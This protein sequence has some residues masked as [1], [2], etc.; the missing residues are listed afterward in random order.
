[1]PELKIHPDARVIFWTLHP[2]N[3]IQTIVPLPLFRHLQSRYCFMDRMA[4]RTFFRNLHAR[5][6][7]LVLAM[8]AE[9]SLFFM[10]GPTLRVT[11][12]RLDLVI[13]NPIIM[14]LSGD[15]AWAKPR[16]LHRDK[17]QSPIRFVWLGRL[18]DFKIHILIHAAHRLSE[19]AGKRGLSIELHVIRRRPEG[20]KTGPVRIGLSWIS[21]RQAGRA[22]RKKT[23]E[24]LVLHAD[25][26]LAMGMAACDGAKLGI[27]TILLDF[28]YAP[29]LR[30]YRFRWLFEAKDY[31]LGDV[32]GSEH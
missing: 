23:D 12:E 24:Y 7:S 8:A 28:S 25:V 9:K 26:L 29:I 15:T 4:G 19:L 21:P 6:R 17:A 31:S 5:L 13:S 2:L 20:R 32:I 1:M 11:Q 14:P 22:V 27:P 30:N 10:D 16:S 3:L 18:C